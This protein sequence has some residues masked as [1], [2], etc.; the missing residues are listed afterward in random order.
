MNLNY[1]TSVLIEVGR[2]YKLLAIPN[3][4][5]SRNY[6]TPEVQSKQKTV[7]AVVPKSNQLT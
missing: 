1:K 2:K 3:E 5:H 7:V 4:P 6:R